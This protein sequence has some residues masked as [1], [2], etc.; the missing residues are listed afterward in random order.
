ME[1]KH[2]VGRKWTFGKKKMVREKGQLGEGRSGE[3]SVKNI[4]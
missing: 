3:E 2:G 1:K 4:D